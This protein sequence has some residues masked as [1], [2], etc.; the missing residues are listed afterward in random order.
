MSDDQ[1]KVAEEAA[2]SAKV[3]WLWLE[4]S[5]KSRKRSE[6]VELLYDAFARNEV[7]QDVE[8]HRVRKETKNQ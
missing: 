1:L 5:D 7:V 6:I 3:R 2:T 4:F 8:P